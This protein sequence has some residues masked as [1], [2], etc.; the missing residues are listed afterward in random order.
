LASEHNRFQTARRGYDPAAVERELVSI[1]SELVRL[2]SQNAELAAALKSTRQQLAQAETE[3]EA[4]R[5]PNYSSLGSK[6]AELLITAESI[7]LEL[8]QQTELEL[9]GQRLSTAIELAELQAK[10]EASYQEQLQAATRRSA[11]AMATAKHEA[12]LLVA[13][14]MQKAEAITKEVEREA[15]KVRGRAA[16]EVAAIRSNAVREIE[17]RRAQAEKDIAQ[18]RYLLAESFGDD[19]RAEE[20]AKT[21]LEAAL[22]ERNR[23]AEAEFTDKHGEAVRQSE[24]YLASAKHDLSEL[25]QSIA[26]SR[27]EIQA[28]EMD[29]GNTQARLIQDARE[30][31]EAIVHAAEL[32]ATELKLAAQK[33]IAKSQKD[34]KIALKVIENRVAASDIYLKNLRSVV[35][36]QGSSED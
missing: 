3:L 28:L 14:A 22:S 29:A 16:T 30:R 19:E 21:K 17:L 7:A 4:S 15:A 1:N 36:D 2:Q 11:R 25:Q 32:E 31:A 24:Q 13:Q 6:A 5:A 26:L 27:L 10:A 12:E 8:S 20:L 23:Q 9:E 34:A 18:Q 33:E 35:L